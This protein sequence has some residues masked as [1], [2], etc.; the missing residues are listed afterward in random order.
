ME[1]CVVRIEGGVVKKCKTV[2]KTLKTVVKIKQF[3]CLEKEMYI[4]H[5]LRKNTEEGNLIF[6]VAK[7]GLPAQR[8]IF[9]HPA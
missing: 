9:S 7:D 2:V 5:T 1:G 3:I 6:R 4:Y 8:E